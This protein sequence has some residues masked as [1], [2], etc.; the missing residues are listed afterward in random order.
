MIILYGIL[1]VVRACFE[2]QAIL[3]RVRGT[4][5]IHKVNTEIFVVISAKIFIK[6]GNIALLVCKNV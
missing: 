1:T 5:E 4:L 3:N 2:R 6:A